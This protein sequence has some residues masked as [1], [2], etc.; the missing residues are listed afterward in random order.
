M[1]PSQI[2]DMLSLKSAACSC[3]ALEQGDL[4]E[5]NQCLAALKQLY[6]EGVRTPPLS[7]LLQACQKCLL[8]A[9]YKGHGMPLPCGEG[10]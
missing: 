4:A 3:A 7:P 9:S 1:C 8:P 6:A 5:F 10:A 2:P